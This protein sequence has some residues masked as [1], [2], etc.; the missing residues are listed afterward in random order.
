MTKPFYANVIL[1]MIVALLVVGCGSTPQ[2]FDVEAADTVASS[3]P[4][5][6]C[7]TV[8]ADGKVEL[9]DYAGKKGV[10]MDVDFDGEYELLLNPSFDPEDRPLY[11]RFDVYKITAGGRELLKDE[12]YNVFYTHTVSWV[13]ANG[14]EIDYSKQQIV[15]YSM[16]DNSCSDYGTQLTDTYQYNPMTKTFKK[17]REKKSYDYSWE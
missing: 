11:K 12:P 16:T 14:L 1:S 13:V 10:Y 8:A 3:V 7:D 17:S 2:T 6:V 15:R 4:C 9:M 5:D